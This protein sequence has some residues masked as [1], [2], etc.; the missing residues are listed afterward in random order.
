[1]VRLSP[2]SIGRLY[3][4]EIFL[5][6]ISVRGWVNPR[7]IVRP[8]GLRQWKI[9]MTPS[10]IEPA[11]FRLAAQCLSQL[12]RKNCGGTWVIAWGGGPLEPCRE[13]RPCYWCRWAF[14]VILLRLVIPQQVTTCGNFLSGL[15]DN[16]TALSLAI[17]CKIPQVRE[18]VELRNWTFLA[19][20]GWLWSRALVYVE[21]LLARVL[22]VC[23]FSL[24]LW[25]IVCLVWS[26]SYGILMKSRALNRSSKL[27]I[28]T[29]LIRPVVTYGCEA[30]T[31]TNRD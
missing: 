12:R 31:L 24:R 25:V 19:V 8:Q 11:T 13:R 7:A 10:G 29:S 15:F 5:V 4:Q 16:V 17:I 26:Y 21:T 20:F 18:T 6:V 9:P 22:S 30:W 27:K 2:L 28:Y 1:M 3:S 23:V 14:R